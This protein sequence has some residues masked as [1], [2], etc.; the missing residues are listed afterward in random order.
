[1][2]RAVAIVGWCGR[3]GA[4]DVGVEWWHVVVMTFCWIQRWLKV[5][6]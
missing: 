2:R 1:M 4:G 5:R 3:D 6:L